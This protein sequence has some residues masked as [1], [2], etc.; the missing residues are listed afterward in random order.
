MLNYNP[1]PIMNVY[2]N[3][4]LQI[5]QDFDSI[6]KH[7]IDEIIKTLRLEEKRDTII[8]SDRIIHIKDGKIKEA[9]KK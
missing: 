7:F 3:I 9:R 1:I 8:L 5:E 4:V 6:D 2:E